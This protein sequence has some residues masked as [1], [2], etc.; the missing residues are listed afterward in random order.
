MLCW[1]QDK[2]E[3]IRADEEAAEAA[4]C[5]FQPKIN[6]KSEQMMEMRTSICQVCHWASATPLLRQHGQAY[7]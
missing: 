6:R 5:T 1:L 7:R 3:A 2:M 4:E